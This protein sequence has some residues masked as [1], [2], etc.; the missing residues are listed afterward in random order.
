M[1]G[2]DLA[3]GNQT[4]DRCVPSCVRGLLVALVLVGLAACSDYTEPSGA[5]TGGSFRAN[6]GDGVRTERVDVPIL[7]QHTE[8]EALRRAEDW[9]FHA[10]VVRR[11]EACRPAGMVIDQAPAAGT[12]VIAARRLTIVVANRRSA[13]VLCGEGI[14]SEH[15]R[16]LA[17]MLYSFSREPDGNAAPWAPRVTLL[18]SD[19][20]AHKTITERQAGDPRQ[21][22]FEE[23]LARLSILHVLASSNG[24]F[25]VDL[26][27]HSLCVGPVRPPPTTFDGLRQIS[28]TPT[29][30]RDSCLDWWA[31][32][33]YVNDVGQ[34][35]GV[36]LDR[37][38][39]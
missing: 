9:G 26:G 33:L 29:A 20:Q 39:W 34:I 21:W 31:V 17:A 19:R 28:I 6:S 38:E 23:P 7:V 4:V 35:Q 15:D 3:R 16:N 25:R 27:P 11:F 14:A 32:D 8:Q 5:V 10:R 2:R 18:A 13:S 30:V 1:G 36:S 24:E 12:K 37:W 22:R